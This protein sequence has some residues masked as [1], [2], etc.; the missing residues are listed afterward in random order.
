MGESEDRHSGRVIPEAEDVGG[1]TQGDRDGGEAAVGGV[2]E[3]GRGEAGGAQKREREDGGLDR[4]QAKRRGCPPSRHYRDDRRRELRA[5]SGSREE[6]V[7]SCL[8]Q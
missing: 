4:D 1:G 8:D 2:Q 6:A 5:Q 7:M 3:A